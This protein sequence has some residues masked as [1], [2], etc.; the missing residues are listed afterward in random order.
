MFNSHP[1]NVTPKPCPECKAAPGH[2]HTASCCTGAKAKAESE[3]GYEEH[4]AGLKR[5]LKSAPRG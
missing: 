4:W 5:K 3:A 1:W 2:P